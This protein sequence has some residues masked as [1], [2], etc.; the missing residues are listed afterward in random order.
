MREGSAVVG[1]TLH[2]YKRDGGERGGV[3]AL[4]RILESA[5]C[6]H[7]GCAPLPSQ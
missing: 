2:K 6:Q 4:T 5:Q 1:R 7:P 3:R